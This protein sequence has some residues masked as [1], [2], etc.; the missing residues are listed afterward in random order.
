M[1]CVCGTAILLTKENF[2]N[3]GTYFPLSLLREFTSHKG[4]YAQCMGMA[5]EF[6]VIICKLR[7]KSLSSSPSLQENHEKFVQSIV[8]GFLKTLS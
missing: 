1:Q 4:A 5:L 6:F 2:H 7:Q 8:L 3:I